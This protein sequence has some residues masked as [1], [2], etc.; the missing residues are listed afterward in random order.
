MLPL[1]TT[2]VHT[3]DPIDQP[4]I[5]LCLLDPFVI[6]NSSLIL[7]IPIGKGGLPSPPHDT[8]VMGDHVY[9]L[10]L[11]CRCSFLCINGFDDNARYRCWI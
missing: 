5:I 2:I 7:L 11:V 8:C 1:K 6:R 9:M 3:L 10:P 4:T